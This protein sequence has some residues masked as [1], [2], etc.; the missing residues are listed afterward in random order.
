MKTRI[1]FFIIFLSILLFNDCKKK[2][3]NINKQKDYFLFEECETPCYKPYHFSFK[4]ADFVQYECP[5]FLKTALD[6]IIHL[7]KLKKCYDSSFTAYDVFFMDETYE[8]ENQYNISI[9][10]NYNYFIGNY[11]KVNGTK[12]YFVYRNVV[13]FIFDQGYGILD[14]LNKLNF[15]TFTFIEQNGTSCYIFDNEYGHVI[16][17]F[18]KYKFKNNKLELERL[19]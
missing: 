7:G 8:G 5:L 19:N 1:Y 17:S 10:P 16:E 12:S 13:F 15:A 11:D 3:V 14:S 2:E 6:S 9:Y 18:V 4:T